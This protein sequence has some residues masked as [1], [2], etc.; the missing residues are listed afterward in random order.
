MQRIQGLRVIAFGVA[1]FILLPVASFAQN[2][3]IAGVVRDT[4]G[5]VLP[6]VTVEASSPA[7][8]EKAR[9]VI[10]DEQGLYHIVDLRPGIYS[11]TFTLTGFSTVRRD[12]IELSAAFTATVNADLRV[13]ALE[14]TV[15]VSGAT[16]VVDIQNVIQQKVLSRQLIDNLPSGRTYTG[17][18]ALLPGVMV[19]GSSAGAGGNQDVGGSAGST[20]VAMSIHG[21]RGGDQTLFLDGLRFNN[22][23]GQAGGGAYTIYMNT[24]SI[25]EISVTTDQAASEIETGGIRVNI[26]PKEGGNTFRGYFFG[27]FT[28]SSLQGDNLTPELQARGISAVSGIDK[29]WDINP[30]FGGPLL[31]DKLWFYTAHRWWGSGKY[32]AGL[33]YN[34]DPQ[35]W[36]YT[37]DLSRQAVD[38]QDQRSHNLRLTWQ[39]NPKNKIT[40]FVDDQ[41]QCWCHFG[42]SAGTSSPEAVSLYRAEPSYIAQVKWSAPLTNKLFFE[43]GASHNTFD[44]NSMPTDGATLDAI[45]VLELSTNFTYRARPTYSRDQNF[46]A[47]MNRRSTRTQRAAVSYVT[48]SHAFQVGTVLF[49]GT[50]RST[51]PVSGGGMNYQFLNGVPRTVVLRAAPLHTRENLGMNLGVFAQDQWTIKRLTLNLG[52]RYG[53]HNSYVLAQSVP[54]GPFVPARDFPG[55]ED[56]PDWKDLLPRLGVAYDLFGNGKTAVKVSL[57]KYVLGDGVTVPGANNPQNTAVNL[58]TRAWN[59]ANGN[60]VPDCNLV[61]PV[62]N[63]ECGPMSDALFGKQ[64]ITGTRYDPDVL[65]GFGKRNYNWQFATGVQHELLPS[66]SLN[67]T[68]NRRSYGNFQVVDNLATTLADFDPYCVTAPADPRLPGVGGNQIC[69]LYDIKPAKFG[70]VSNLVTDAKHYGNYIDVYNGVDAALNARLARGIVLQ[71]GTSTGRERVDNCDLVSEIDNPAAALP[72]YFFGGHLGPNVSGTASPSQ[73]FCNVAPRFLTQLKVLGVYPLPWWGL[74]TS[75]TFQ[76]MPG[77][78]ITALYVASNA[79]VAPSL[80]RNLAAGAAGTAS[81]QLIEPGTQFEK[82]LNQLDFRVSR[83]FKVG[84]GVS[85]IQGTIDVYNLLN[86]SS[87]LAL[88][89]RYGASWLRPTAILPARFVKFGVQLEF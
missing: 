11:V 4:T 72:Y 56:V 61:D 46:G 38:N 51:I 6:G 65:R 32:V 43:A 49:S 84:A 5:A 26:I 16:P 87:I 80:G 19:T 54:A 81:L 13:G 45:S 37:P 14:E 9:T 59:D 18:A 63:G 66:V 21:G 85:R 44:P 83:F 73:R 15:T 78:E 53:S 42:I 7:L 33:Y 52:L 50:S 31:Q 82:R 10:T 55:V 27:D 79:Q 88:N 35:A 70:Q 24:G 23:L 75:A 69:G 8:I 58:V 3:A 74:Q 64:I 60:Y 22:I 34:K 30:A 67:V 1:F 89:T 28:N 68:Y 29:I 17:V 71:G 48:G 47:R 36:T 12:G 62:G 77:P 39:V 86:A 76:S 41:W 57:S 40:A 2:G 20:N 25:Q